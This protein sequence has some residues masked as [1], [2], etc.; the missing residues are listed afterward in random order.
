[1][2]LTLS[3]KPAN[4]IRN[5][6]LFLLCSAVF[7]AAEPPNW[8]RLP[9][10]N[11]QRP[12]GASAW[13]LY[14][15]KQITQKSDGSIVHHYRYAVMLLSETGVKNAG[16][17]MGF[18][19]GFE[20]VVLLN[21][22]AMSPN[23]K[24][25]R[26]FGNSEF[27][28]GS[29][30]SNYIWDLE[31]AAQFFPARYLQPGWIFA[32]EIEIKSESN[33]FDVWW[34]P[35]DSLPTRFSS[36]EIVPAEGGSVRW[37]AFSKD[38]PAPTGGRS[39]GSLVW[40]IS[41]MKGY[42]GNVPPGFEPNSM[43]LRAYLVGPATGGASSKTWSDVV[44]L[45][46]AEIDP[47]IAATPAIDAEAHRLAG[48]GG[49]WTRIA[50]VCR[51]VQKQ[52]SYLHIS[53]DADSMAGY[54]PHLA[55]EIIANRYGDCKDKAV[56]LCT[57]LRA[58]GVDA[59]VILVTSGAPMANLP[60]WPSAHFNHAIVAIVC[61]EA[62]PPGWPTVRA[63]NRDYVLFD[64]TDEDVPFGLLPYQDIGGLGLVLAPD[65]T[66]PVLIPWYPEASETISISVDA[67]LVKDGSARIEVSE[68]RAGLAAAL[69]VAA[70]ATE[71][72]SERTGALERR[73]QRRVPLMSD[74]SWESSGDEQGR[75]WHRTARFSAQRMGQ[76]IPG[77]GMYV[78]TDLMSVMPDCEPW[79]PEAE[80]WVGFR[81][82]SIRREIQLHPPAGWEFTEVP[83]DWSATTEAGEGSVHY[84][85]DG[86]VLKGEIKLR[87]HG[88]ILD[89]GAYLAVR[90]LVRSAT[91]AERRPVMLHRAIPT[92]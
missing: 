46:R 49:L 69:A 18:F 50:P 58:I 90:S 33:P 55:D 75:H 25:C 29:P 3:V 19:E 21:A 66:S 17:F 78:A 76:R 92:G 64:P 39:S 31:K 26:E 27:I 7:R 28:I 44:R 6:V 72:R 13:I 20:K 16:C 36:L 4:S 60:D 14:N 82:R 85:Q 30:V 43:E 54:R 42:D 9:G 52:I 59:R 67:T 32:W 80:G 22:W 47:K 81:P 91:A 40:T 53:I 86:G 41:D 12:T 15:S 10:E 63:G 23:G 84:W 87:I 74:L 34:S 71:P 79:V 5:L 56:L 45:A 73:I 70:D 51:F 37:K 83:E 89:R 57:M 24:E 65:V 88:G 68:E 1:M 2:N 77:G 35:R 62:A 48:Q 11:D 38:L 8:L 61:S